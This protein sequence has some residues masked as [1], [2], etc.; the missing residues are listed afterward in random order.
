MGSSYY[1]VCKN[2]KDKG[3]LVKEG[4]H[5]LDKYKNSEAYISA[6]KYNE[7]HKKLFDKTNSVAGF[8]DV[9][10]DI[11]YFDLDNT[12]IE[13]ARQDTIT[14][15]DRLKEYDINNTTIC[16]SGGKGYHLALHSTTSFSPTEARTLAINLA[17]DLP[18]FDSS[19]YNANRIIRI[20]GSVH[21]KTGLRKTRIS[22]EELR[23]LKIADL[24]T[25]ANSEYEYS[26]PTKETLKE[27]FLALSKPITKVANKEIELKDNVDYISNPYALQPWKLALSQGF[28][29]DGN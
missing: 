12:D 26:K 10:T 14:V 27:A 22:E 15:L 23:T 17:G 13:L 1:R 2:L 6:F 4:Q 11:L 20:E 3:I 18:S 28:F 8:S 24:K 7:E 21:N 29:P 9:T 5:D 25:L 19:I 16:L